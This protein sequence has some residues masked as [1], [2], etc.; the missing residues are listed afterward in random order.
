[1]KPFLRSSS[2]AAFL[3]QYITGGLF[4]NGP[5]RRE[6][7]GGH[8][9]LGIRQFALDKK[10]PNLSV[11]AITA[12]SQGKVRCNPSRLILAEQLRHSKT[13]GSALRIRY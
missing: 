1:L 8:D 4:L 11:T 5:R 3:A 13:L 9:L 10:P 6:T 12:F 2:L 7:A